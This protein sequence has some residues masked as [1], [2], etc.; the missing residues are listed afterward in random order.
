MR[1]V[2]SAAGCR[3]SR[4]CSSPVRLALGGLRLLSA[5]VRLLWHHLR[6]QLGVGCQ[7]AAEA[8]QMQPWSWHQRRQALHELPAATP[9]GGWCRRAR[10]YSASTRLAQR[11]CIAHGRWLADTAG[12]H[13]NAPT[14]AAS[15]CVRKVGA[16]CEAP[17]GRGRYCGLSQVPTLLPESFIVM[18]MPWVVAWIAPV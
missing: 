13:K 18:F 9:P 5:L 4:S 10:V 17:T 6:T 7:H 2:I 1:R 14:T 16:S 8:D 11:R 12:A 15:N 3:S